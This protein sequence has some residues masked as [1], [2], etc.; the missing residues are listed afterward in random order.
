MRFAIS[1]S[2]PYFGV[3]PDKKPHGATHLPV[4][5]GGSSRAVAR[6][7]GQRGDGYFPGGALTPDERRLQIE[8]ARPTAT[9]AGR[10]ADALEYTRWG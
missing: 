6:R 5:I 8:L 3:D 7:S 2:T 10:S 9:D 1:Y 4:H